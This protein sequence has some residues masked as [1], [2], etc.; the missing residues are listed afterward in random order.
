MAQNWTS[1]CQVFKGE[2][3]DKTN[4]LFSVKRPSIFQKKTKLEVF[5]ATNKDEK[6]CDY[7]VQG[8]WGKGTCVVYAGESSNIVAQ[9]HK[10]K[11]TAKNI[12]FG[13]NKFKVTVYP[14]T[15]YRLIT[16]IFIIMQLQAINRQSR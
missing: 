2:S 15:D 6:V 8:S 13:N 3:S 1:T 14:N 4:L 5:L 12:L 16:S 9:M 7:K 10:K 11:F